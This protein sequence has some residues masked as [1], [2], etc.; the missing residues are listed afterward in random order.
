MF[1]EQ[2]NTPIKPTWC[3][4]CGNFGI[5]LALKKTFTRLKW[6]A[7]DFNVV[8][9]I[10]CSGNMGDFLTVHGFHSLHGRAIPAAVGMRLADPSK[11]VV[12]V[13]G[14]GG[15]YG[16]GG[17]HLLAA[18]RGN[19]DV[20]VLVHDN[21]VYGLTT[22]QAS[23]TSPQ[24]YQS[25]STPQGT[26][27]VPL[28]PLALAVSQGATF[29]AQGFAG[30]AVQL[31]ELI[32]LAIKHEGFSLV[33]ILQPCVTFNAV[34]TYEHYREKIYKIEKPLMNKKLAL[35]ELID[36]PKIPTGVI[37]CRPRPTYE[38]YLPKKKEVDFGA[39]LEEFK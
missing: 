14:D 12:V 26:V 24:G 23:P 5:W 17:N 37:Y 9:D 2:F 15:A 3:P 33:N 35:N 29:V 30:E 1:E 18:C 20:T 39:L 28:N 19:F 38:S 32:L 11:P 8:Y 22:G 6:Q 34:N 13:T 16:E 36:N 31:N 21:R 25:K 27:E 7:G 10:G 4:G